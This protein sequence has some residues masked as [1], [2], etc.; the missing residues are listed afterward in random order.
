MKRR[1]FF[2][3]CASAVAAQGVPLSTEH[4]PLAKELGVPAGLDVT[5]AFEGWYPNPDG[6]ATIYFG[7]YNR[8]TE[9]VVHVPAGPNNQVTELRFKVK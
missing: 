3:L 7:Y 2:K 5:P 1:A 6:T 4:L 9:E 8:N